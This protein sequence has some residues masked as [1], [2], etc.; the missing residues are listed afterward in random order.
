[1]ERLLLDVP[2]NTCRVFVTNRDTEAMEAWRAYTKRAMIEQHIEEPLKNSKLSCTRT[3][4]ACSRFCDGIGIPGSG[5]HL[6]SF[7][8]VSK[9]EDAGECLPAARNIAEY[10]VVQRSDSGTRR[11][12]IVVI[13]FSCMERN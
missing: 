1:M 7:E 10:R 2:E 8:P 11:A 3:D 6:K 5:I 4:F 9:G 12:Q 13:N